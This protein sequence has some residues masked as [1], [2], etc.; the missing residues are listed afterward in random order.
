MGVEIELLEP[1]LVVAEV[2]ETLGLDPRS[3]DLASPEVLAAAIR[4]AASFLCPTTPHVLLGAVGDSLAGLPG[5][6]PNM[7]DRLEELL[8][9]MIGYGDLL[10]LSLADDLS[11]RRR[12]YLGVPAFVPRKRSNAV[13][14]C[15]VRPEGTPLVGEDILELVEHDSHLRVIR[16]ASSETEQQLL[17]SGLTKLEL[18]H[19]LRAPRATAPAELIADYSV[20]LEGAQPA[21]EVEGLRVL[22]PEASVTYYRG[23]WRTLVEADVGLFVG[24]RTQRFGADLWCLV[25]VTRGSVM[26][27]LDLPVHSKLG[28]GAD[29]AWR[30]QAAFDAERHDPQRLRVRPAGQ[31]R[32]VIVDLF[33][34]VPSW[35]QRRLDAVGTKLLEPGRALFSYVL[36]EDEVAEELAFAHELLWLDQIVEDADRR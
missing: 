1:S 8:E 25:H 4:R 29:E 13:F 26:K 24:R 33:S 2:V 10:E 5:C 12:L 6:D 27:L 11:A 34:P 32:A 21:G 28:A 22:A 18:E 20:R 36:P 7:M 14:L 19:W 17:A 16:N 3:L 15:G 23:R 30:L 31:P 35:M 9:A